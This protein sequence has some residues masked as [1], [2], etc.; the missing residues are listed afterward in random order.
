MD[1]HMGYTSMPAPKQW[2]LGK[3]IMASIMLMDS[4]YS[5]SAND[6]SS[7]WNVITVDPIAAR[8]HHAPL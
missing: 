6:M 2:D 4:G 5:A 3:S 8:M 1:P 7:V